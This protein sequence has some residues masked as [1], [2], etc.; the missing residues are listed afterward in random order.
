[1]IQIA[2]FVYE[3]FDEKRKK[4]GYHYFFPI[5]KMFSKALFSKV[6][7][8]FDK[9]SSFSQMT[10]FRLFQTERLKFADENFKFDENSRK[11]AKRVENTLEKG[12][13]DRYEEFLLFPQCFLKTCIGDT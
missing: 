3:V 10:N 6:V 5:P 13:I 9:R 4:V 12:E 8:M 2:G 7:K 11:F 1:M